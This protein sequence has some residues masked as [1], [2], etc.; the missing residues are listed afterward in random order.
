MTFKN[1]IKE[2]RT[3]RDLT[4]QALADA[5]GISKQAISAY[6]QGNRKPNF[7]IADA[8]AEFFGVSIG[9]LSGSLD[10]R[11]EYPAA[12][13]ATPTEMAERDFR[14]LHKF[15]SL[16]SRDQAI[17]ESMMDSMLGHQ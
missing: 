1:R 15:R 2:L 11:G 13:P 4:Q 6:E 12:H 3:E 7:E 5:L 16:T 17:I 9:Y 8:L 14:I 10:E